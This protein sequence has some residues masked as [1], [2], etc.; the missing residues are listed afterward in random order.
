MK[1]NIKSGII[2]LLVGG[3][4]IYWAQTHSPKKLGQAIGNAFSG[5]YTMDE[6]SYYICLGVGIAIGVFGLLKLIR[7]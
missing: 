6:T 7:K 4:F 2:F 3:F 1:K 5:S